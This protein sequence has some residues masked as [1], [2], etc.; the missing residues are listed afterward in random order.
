MKT[1]KIRAI[2]KV[3]KEP[4]FEFS[5]EDVLR[6]RV[7]ISYPEHWYFLEYIDAVDKDK[8]EIYEGDILDCH[9][10]N[11]LGSYSPMKAEV[12]WCENSLR[13]EVKPIG[14]NQ[15]DPDCHHWEIG[16]NVKVISN[17]YEYKKEETQ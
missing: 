4:T 2:S 6:H 10:E 7:T 16:T 13:F 12:F 11:G 9:L 14:K 3:K 15:K 5:L 8:K 17:I 1:V